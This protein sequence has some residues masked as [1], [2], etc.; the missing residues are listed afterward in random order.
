M[1]IIAY[2]SFREAIRSRCRI[3]STH[4]SDAHHLSGQQRPRGG[5]VVRRQRP[6]HHRGDVARHGYVRPRG[7]GGVLRVGAR[8]E[9]RGRASTRVSFPGGGP[10]VECGVQHRCGCRRWPPASSTAA[11]RTAL[12]ILPRSLVE[13]GVQHRCGLGCLDN[14][15]GVPR[16]T[17]HTFRVSF[18]VGVQHPRTSLGLSLQ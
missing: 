6:I 5:R 16:H 7:A 17:P 13:C 1:D 3:S 2:N 8:R 10:P 12:H 9:P 18:E 14:H 4:A 11:F 15:S